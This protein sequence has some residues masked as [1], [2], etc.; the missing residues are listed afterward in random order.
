LIGFCIRSNLE[1][2]HRCGILFLEVAKPHDVYEALLSERIGTSAR[3][4][5]IRISPNFYV[6]EEV[7]CRVREVLSRLAL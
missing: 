1:E 7:V 6:T 2:R 5:G 3:G 4:G